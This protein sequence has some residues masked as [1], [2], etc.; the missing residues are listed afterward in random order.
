MYATFWG[1]SRRI[2]CV[3]PVKSSFWETQFFTKDLVFRSEDFGLAVARWTS[4]MAITWSNHAEIARNVGH[5]MRAYK[6]Y[7]LLLGKFARSARK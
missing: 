4:K 1:Y 7:G 2:G 3:T 6:L 5:L